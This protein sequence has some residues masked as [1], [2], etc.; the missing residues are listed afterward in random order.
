MNTDD[1][2]IQIQ[3][4]LETETEGNEAHIERRLLSAKQQSLSSQICSQNQHMIWKANFPDCI[5][6][7]INKNLF[8]MRKCI[9]SVVQH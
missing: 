6:L 2:A 9:K 4:K 1:D 3:I 8:T 5:S 7:T